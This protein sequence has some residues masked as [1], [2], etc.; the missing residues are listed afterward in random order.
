MSCK[1]AFHIRLTLFTRPVS[2]YFA[3]GKKQTTT[4]TTTAKDPQTPFIGSTCRI[5]AQRIRNQMSD[6]SIESEPEPESELPKPN[7]ELPEPELPD[8]NI[9]QEVKKPEF[10]SGNS[11]FD[12]RYPNY[13]N[14]VENPIYHGLIYSLDPTTQ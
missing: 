12:S 4:I 7:P 13:P 3:I 9:G 14:F 8:H 1:Q 6:T 2:F 10:N 11:G 5:S